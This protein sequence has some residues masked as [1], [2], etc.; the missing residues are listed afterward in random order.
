MG[1]RFFSPTN[2]VDGR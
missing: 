2:S 1:S